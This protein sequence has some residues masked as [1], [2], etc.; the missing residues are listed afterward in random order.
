[1]S[2][3]VC[4]ID[5]EVH[6]PKLK[7]AGWSWKYHEGYILCTS[8]FYENLDE[9]K[10][11]PG[12][13][14]DNCTYS[15]EERINKNEIIKDLLKNENVIIIGANIIYDI[16]WLLYEYNMTTYDVKAKLIDVLMAQR[17]LDEWTI[18]SLESLSQMYL[19][20][21]K[22]TS[23]I[24]PWIKEH[25]S[26]KGD[27]RQHLKEAPYNLLL[28]Y[29]AV[30]SKNPVKIWKKQLTLLKNE[31]LVQRVKLEFS[32]ILPILQI[33]INGFCFNVEGKKENLKL[34]TKYRDILKESFLKNYNLDK[35]N[36]NSSQHIA[37]LCDTYDI[38]YKY[39]IT[40]KTYEGKNI[41]NL[42]YLN[43]VYNIAKKI[44]VNI[45]KVKNQLVAFVPAN[46]V[47]RT[48]DLL[49]EEGFTC[50]ASPN[51]DKKFF[52]ANKD[53][54]EVID[55][56]A[57][58]KLANGIISKILGEA[59]DRFITKDND[60]VYRVHGQF[61]ISNTVTFRLSSQNPN[62]ITSDN[63]LLTP[64]GY[65]A[66]KN[67]KEGDYVY[68]GNGDLTTIKNIWYKGNRKC[69]SLVSANGSKIVL[70]TD[71]KL[72]NGKYWEKAGE[73]EY[74]DIVERSNGTSY[75]NTCR[76]LTCS[77]TRTS[78]RQEYLKQQLGQLGSCYT[79][80]SQKVTQ[81]DEGI[82]EVYDIEVESSDH[83]FIAEGYRVKNCQ[84][85]PSKGALKLHDVELSFPALTRAL[86]Q[87]NPNQV[88]WKIDYGQIEYRLICNIAVGEGAEEVRAEFAKNPKLDFHQYAVDLTK[89]SRKFAKNMSFGCFDKNSYFLTNK[90]YVKAHKLF[91]DA[92]SLSLEGKKQKH[93]IFYF[94]DD[95]LQFTLSNGIQFCVTENHVFIDCQTIEQ[96][97][98]KLAK[99][100]EIGDRLPQYNYVENINCD[101]TNICGYDFDEHMAYIAGLYIGDGR[102]SSSVELIS[103]YENSEI[104]KQY[105]VEKNITFTFR[106]ESKIVRFCV[107][108]EAKE[109]F[110]AFGKGTKDKRIPEFVYNSNEKVR[111]AFIA[112]ML[113]SDGSVR[114]D[115]IRLMGTNEKLMRD[116]AL[117]CGT[118]NFD[119]G[120][121]VCY[122]DKKPTEYILLIY[123]IH[124]KII[125]SIYRKTTIRNNSVTDVN[126]WKLEKDELE[127]YRTRDLYKT[128]PKLYDFLRGHGC[129]YIHNNL[130]LNLWQERYTPVK[131]VDIKKVKGIEFVYLETSTKHYIANG[132]ATHNCSFG[133]SVASMAENFGWTLEHATEI[134]EQ[135]HEHMPFVLPTLTLVGDI[136]KERGYIRTV[137][138]SHA[139]LQNESKSYTMLNRYTQGS[140]AEILKT[141]ITQAYEEGL[142]KNL[143]VVNT[144]HDE[145]VGS[146]DVNFDRILDVYKMAHVM[147]TCVKLRVPLEAEP[148]FGDNWAS[149]KTVSEWIEEAS[150]NSEAWIKA[151]K[152]LKET[153]RICKIIEQKANYNID[154]L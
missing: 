100:M 92:E 68:N 146:V 139:R 60:G 29:V 104:V 123:N 101:I 19:G 24:E 62:C 106:N 69:I 115:A 117:L 45:R 50:N 99:D 74:A 34:L 140:G 114:K 53:K 37:D 116:F 124:N 44:I 127:C 103:H 136:A 91:E 78:H 111:L 82:R 142:W 152:Q 86:F 125:P 94:K 131:I 55:I 108:K 145:L 20:Y 154:N 87:A 67:L 96:G 61:S 93:K 112:G 75:R 134:A 63:R 1:M 66:L 28:D 51:V 121:T 73:I 120:F 90:G 133:M 138:G 79:I 12:I 80:S 72:W 118:L 40:L 89:L 17:I 102:I 141:A 97:K 49:E 76:V 43:K 77:S 57:N 6:D 4:G 48:V 84:Q 70:T 113:D 129:K 132:I 107:H 3:I 126:G 85:I 21:G 119:S 22:Q 153:V 64:S 39:K 30:D 18:H 41:D 42:D 65:V 32:C 27:F 10:I 38:P 54:Y 88:L 14:N 135:Y 148:E 8:I 13:H 151:S 71:H 95:G 58:W 35:F 59:Y 105:L 56:I 26:S 149:T 46:M 11:I 150:K 98:Y 36:V 122:R 83:S 81:A 110:S 25:V 9:V 128:N 109:F 147:R 47:E 137:C 23:K 144:I 52:A 15:E 130:G 33:T 2:K 5:C 31:N 16:G 143:G 7:T